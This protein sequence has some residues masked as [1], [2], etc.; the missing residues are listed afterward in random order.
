YIYPSLS[1]PSPVSP[2]P[3]PPEYIKLVED[4]IETLRASLA[5]AMLETMTLRARVR[6]LEQYDVVTQESLT[7]ARGRF[8]Q[9]QL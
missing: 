9:S 2:S 6:S 4:N 1:L 7:I 3:P 5:S 8:T